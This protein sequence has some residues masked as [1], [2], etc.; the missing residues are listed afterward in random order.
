MKRILLIHTGG[1]FG[2]V[3]LKPDKTL[4]PGNLQ[5]QLYEYVPELQ[6]LAEIDI[7]IPFNLDSSD[8][9]CR[10]WDILS[11]L[12]HNSMEKYDGFVII[13]GTDTMVYTAAALSFSLRNLKKPVILTGSQRPLSKLRSDARA[14]LIDAVELATCSLKEVAIVFGQSVLRGNRARKTS[15]T[16]Y[17]A[18]QSPNYP[19]LGNIGLNIELYDKFLFSSPDPYQYVPGFTGSVSILNVLPAIKPD[20]YFSL[21][22]TNVTALILVAFGAGNFPD[23]LTGWIPLIKQASEKGI[24][25]LV[26]SHSL[27]GTIDLNIYQ[28]GRNALR[29]GAIGL[30]DMTTEATYVK[31]LKLQSMASDNNILAHEILTNWAGEISE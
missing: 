31:L 11:F 19:R 15:I 6:N 30:K 3:P 14:N 20:L 25:V 27:H 16:S 4:A 2:M 23:T 18:F 21:L 10:E 1:T 8:I 24:A 12:I 28:S 17:N 9:S 5:N 26:G 7:R 29:A 22:D 13:H